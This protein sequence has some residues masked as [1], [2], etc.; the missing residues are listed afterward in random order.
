MNFQGCFF[1]TNYWDDDEPSTGGT[2]PSPTDRFMARAHIKNSSQQINHEQQMT[3]VI[4][5]TIHHQHFLWFIIHQNPAIS[6]GL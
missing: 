2:Q 4:K 3:N 5:P 1:L 6:S